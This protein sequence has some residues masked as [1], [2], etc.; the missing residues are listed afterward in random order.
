[1]SHQINKLGNFLI[2][3]L[4]IA[5]IFSFYELLLIDK[6]NDRDSQDKLNSVDE[7]KSEDIILIPKITLNNKKIN[8]YAKNYV[9]LD[10]KSSYPLIE[11]DSLV[12]VPIAST[13]KIMTAMIVLEKYKL[14]DIITISREAANQIGS[15]I[16][17]KIGEK[18]SVESLLYAL[19]VQSGN[20]AAYALAENYPGGFNE[21]IKEMNNKAKYLSM[22]HTLYFD[23]AGLDDNSKS[24]AYDLTIITRYALTSPIFSKIINTTD[25][26]IYST[27]GKLS[28]K[29]KSSNRL[30]KSDEPL[31]LSYAAGVKTGFTPI[32]GHCLVSSAERDDKKL[33]GV[34]LNTYEST[35][36]AS[37]KESRKLL[38]WGFNDY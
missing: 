34:I 4:V 38:E 25:Y 5:V 37:A 22:T 27:D 2:F 24:S 30:I 11:K 9:L 35:N 19:L 13:T 16:N 36:D 31:Y 33:I 14:S 26:T 1:M 3:L 21:F 29:L 32:A 18:L 12:E 10:E 7:F 15:E 20:D 28:H 17:L 6:K 8:I 23:P